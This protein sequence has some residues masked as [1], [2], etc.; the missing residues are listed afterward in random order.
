MLRGDKFRTAFA[1][2]GNIRSLLPKNINVMVLTATAT[3][4]TLSSVKSRLTMEDPVIVG[5]PPNRPNI[6]MNV[7][8]CPDLSALC[9][10]LA[11]DLRE[12]RTKAT[13]TD[14]FCT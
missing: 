6:K 12:N 13:K 5:L 11:K 1:D 4:T 9:E 8:P 2:I 3:R 7:E 10:A 14:V